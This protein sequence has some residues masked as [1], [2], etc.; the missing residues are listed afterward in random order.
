MSFDAIELAL[1]RITDF[2]EFERLATELMYLDG[3]YDIKPLGGT[4]DMGQ[5]AVSE[6][7]FTQAAS[8]RTVFQY[9][10]QQY[11]PGKVTATIEKLRA[12]DV[13]FFELIVVTP[14]SISSETQIKMQRSARS[15][16]SVAL[17]IFDRKTLLSRL[18][19]LDNGIFHRHFPNIKAQVADIVRSADRAAIPQKALERTL[20]QVSLALT[21]RPGALRVRKSLFDHFVLAV[22][23]DTEGPSVQLDV[24]A[25]HCAA[26]LPPDA[27]LPAAQV[28]A[29][30]TRLVKSGLLL[31]THQSVRA[32]ERAVVEVATSTLR[33]SEAT[34]TFAAD[35]LATLTDARG[36]RVADADARRIVRN[37]RAALLEIARSRAATLGDIAPADGKVPTIV[38]NQLA[39]DIGDLLDAALAD[40]LRAPTESQAETIAHWTQAYLGLALMGLDPVLND[41]QAS[42]FSAKTF[43]LDTDIVLEAIVT[44][45][46]RSPAILDV[47]ASLAKHG[48]RLVVPESVVDE[49]VK[50][51]AR[52]KATYRFFGNGLMQLAPAVIEDRVWNAFVKGYYY[53]IVRGRIAKSVRY[54]EYLANFYEETTPNQFF[55]AVITDVLPDEVEILPVNFGR[56]RALDD[57]EVDRFADALQQDLSAR[58]KKSRYRTEEEERALAR[59]DATLYLSASSMN[60]TDETTHKHVLGGTCYLLTE[61]VRYERVAQSVGIATKV[62]VRPGTV[63]GLLKFVGTGISSI[64]FVQL[65]DNPLL[66]RAVSAVWPDM[67]KL[68]RSG[69]DLRAKNLARLRFDCGHALHEYLTALED[70]QDA[71]EQDAEAEASSDERFMELI[72]AAADR[73]YSL[74]PEVAAIRERIGSGDKR[75]EELQGLLDEA[76]SANTELEKEI[77]FFGKRRQKY[78]RRMERGRTK[79]RSRR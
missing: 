49:C 46:T 26:A 30:V 76:M 39:S 55:R 36:Q 79:R 58:S 47:L 16:H 72:E 75:V 31:R 57:A 42:R 34:D 52:S 38:R 54:K 73:G 77:G 61:T 69:V 28:H 70:A 12:N 22:L 64:E 29:A 3:W 20:L 18:A 78:L 51:A 32:S 27:S 59:T 14:H 21:F 40:A 1:D 23:L 9:T 37:I 74:V 10:L 8:Q 15:E 33:L 25:R 24:L 41:F 7:F 2:I 65:F 66:D 60:P 44:D 67:E 62:T 17:N 43:L 53:A 48:C 6:R 35:I 63:A 71:E 4:A 19:D 50:H 68:M 5:D 11:L 56:R 45:G 13:H